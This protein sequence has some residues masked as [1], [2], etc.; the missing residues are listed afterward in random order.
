LYVQGASV[1]AMVALPVSS[2]NQVDDDFEA[3]QSDPL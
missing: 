1:R 3:S 2:L